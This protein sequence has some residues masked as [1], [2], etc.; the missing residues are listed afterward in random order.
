MDFLDWK[1]QRAAAPAAERSV[2]AA[3]RVADCPS[4][5]AVYTARV[6]GLDLAAWYARHADEVSEQL[7]QT[8]AVLFRGFAI[9]GEACFKNFSNVAIKTQAAY[10][11]GATPRTEIQEGVYTSTEF[12]Q[13]HEIQ[14]H[15][16]LS[17]VLSP[18][19]KI[20][21][22][23]LTP[24][25]EGGQTQL[26]DV[27]QVYRNLPASIIEAFEARGGWMLKRNYGHGFGPSVFKSFKL[28]TIEDIRAYC[29]REQ[30]EFTELSE[31][32]FMTRQVRPVVHPHPETGVPLWMNHVAFWH[33]DNLAGEVREKL[34]EMFTL[35]QFPYCTYFGDGTPIDSATVAQ[36]TRAYQ[37]AEVK[38]DW[39]AGDVLLLDNWRIA[40]GRKPFS[41]ARRVIVSM[42]E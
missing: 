5:P 39:R 38:F 14:L 36:V 2:S 6:S 34:A 17:Y 35:D 10:V 16:E 3:G 32:H 28:D 29:E 19:R 41:G 15:N 25:A 11:Q 9:G 22:C 1:K 12:P 21:F 20:A 8:G 23:C 26:A 4:F 7:R 42:G 30:V 33:P 27:H 13:D 24:A 18:P 31:R 37:E 40:H